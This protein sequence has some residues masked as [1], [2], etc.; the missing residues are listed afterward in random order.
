MSGRRPVLLYDGSCEFCTRV[1]TK[2]KAFDR[3][4]N[5]DVVPSQSLADAD[6]ARI[7]VTRESCAEAVQFIDSDA[8]VFSGARA[9][10]RFLTS[11]GYGAALLQFIEKH[12]LLFAVEDR[13]YR[14]VAK[15][16]STIS[17]LLPKP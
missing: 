5:V 11:L 3:R 14:F 6:L 13:L 7:G 12:R 1:V 15:H 16:R 2:A 4:H 17:A 9:A 8:A 10:N